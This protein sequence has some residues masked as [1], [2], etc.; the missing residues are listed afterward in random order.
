MA[1][2]LTLTKSVDCMERLGKGEYLVLVDGKVQSFSH[3][4]DLP[5]KGDIVKFLPEI[6]PGPH[7][8]E[9]HRQI[10]ELP[11]IFAGFLRRMG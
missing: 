6:P 9:Q 8:E 11:A 2:A 4:D 3:W 5:E 7:T 10:D 1:R